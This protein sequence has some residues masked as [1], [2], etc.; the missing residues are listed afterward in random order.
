[1]PADSGSVAS[2]ESPR[3]VE[4]QSYD[5]PSPEPGAVLTEVVRA[6]ICGSE[7]HIWSGNHPLIKDGVLGHEALCRVAELGSGVETDYNGTPIEEGDLVVPAY[8]I[9]CGKCQYCGQGELGH[10]DNAY[11]G[12]SKPPDEWPHYNGTFATHYY[13][14]PD[15]YFYGVPEGIEEGA[16]ASANCALSQVLFGIDEV[17]IEN[18]DTVIVQGVGGLGINAIAV[19]RERG[20]E[21]IAI[22]G[23]DSRLKLAGE[24]GADHR[25]DFREHDTVDDRV[26]RVHEL[27]DGLGGDVAI[28]VTGVPDA[29]SEGIELLRKG[30]RYLEMG[31]IVPGET[32]DFD[33][34]K[35]TR[36]SINIVSTMR[37]DPWYLQEALEFLERHGDE[38]PFGRLLD[39]EFPLEDV[40]HA[41]EES[42]ERTVTRASLV[43]NQ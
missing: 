29:F 7:L 15:Q 39:S 28:E 17:G 36:K 20:A 16:A 13:I 12:W 23:V 6:N 35:L 22:D 11:R 5:L 31:N 33:P 26:D 14:H 41:L 2:L 43:P 19:A 3:N 30:G 32:T 27:T 10:C 18:N 40:D 42:N 34:G 1:M 38:Y 4:I 24:F 8:F 37:Y 25:I 9:T 21:V